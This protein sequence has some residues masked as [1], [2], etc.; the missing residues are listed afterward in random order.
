MWSYLADKRYR[1]ERLLLVFGG[2]VA[3]LAVAFVV[4]LLATQQ[5]GIKKPVSILTADKVQAEAAPTSPATTQKTIEDVAKLFDEGKE[6]EALA[7]LESPEAPPPDQS[8]AFLAE[9]ALASGDYSKAE[10]LLDEAIKISP[11]SHYLRLRGDALRAQNRLEEAMEDYEEALFLNPSDVIASNR[12]L[13]LHIQRGDVELVRETIQ[14]R[15][16]LGV[17]SQTELWIFAAAGVDL[18]QGLTKGAASF[19]HTATTLLDTKTFDTL[20][21]DPIFLPHQNDPLILPYFIKTST[22]RSAL[23]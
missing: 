20:I 21:A 14:L 16:N 11:Q 17:S 13:L 22:A 6:A 10:A 23:R 9:R 18:S 5:S 2:P 1:N 15:L 8:K 7:L 12:R 4:W 19:L 3:I